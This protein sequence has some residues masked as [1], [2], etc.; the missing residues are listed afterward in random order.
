[1]E[2]SETVGAKRILDPNVER[3]QPGKIQG[4]NHFSPDSKHGVRIVVQAPA[5]RA[6]IQRVT[7]G[8]LSH[9]PQT[10]RIG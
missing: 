5:S 6:Q 1:M 2:A 10:D 7:V 9:Y 4:V 3:E 8:I